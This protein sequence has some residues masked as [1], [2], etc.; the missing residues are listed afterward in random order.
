[1]KSVS[2]RRRLSSTARMMCARL[3]PSPLGPSHILPLT[4]VARTTSCRL[5]RSFIQRPM[6][7]SA[8]PPGL[9]SAHHEYTSAVSMKFPPSSTKASIT[10]KPAASSVVQP[11]CIVPKQSSETFK[12][13]LPNFRFFM[14]RPSSSSNANSNQP[15]AL[16]LLVIHVNARYAE[17]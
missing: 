14:L 9:F 15:S 7:C 11:N 8:T 17:C 12:P 4:F 5:P 13:V 2:K 3:R 10:S 6:I 1:M 16:S